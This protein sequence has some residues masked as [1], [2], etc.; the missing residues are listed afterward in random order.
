MSVLQKETITKVD[1]MFKDQVLD[2]FNS[3]MRAFQSSVAENCQ[4]WNCLS[5]ID[6][7]PSQ[8]S[9][10]CAAKQ[11]RSADVC[12]TVT[13]WDSKSPVECPTDRVD[14]VGYCDPNGS[15]YT[16]TGWE[17]AANQVQKILDAFV[18]KDSVD[19]FNV[20]NSYLD[21][22]ATVAM[23]K[24]SL[25]KLLMLQQLFMLGEANSKEALVGYLNDIAKRLEDRYN[26][27]LDM[28]TLTATANKL[29]YGNYEKIAVDCGKPTDSFKN[30]YCFSDF[31]PSPY[32]DGTTISYL[33]TSPQKD[34]PTQESYILSNQI[35]RPSC[36]AS[37]FVTPTNI[38]C[39]IGSFERCGSTT[40]C[41]EA[42]TECVNDK[43]YPNLQAASQC[44]KTLLDLQK[45][46]ID[47]GVEAVYDT[48][49]QTLAPVMDMVQAYKKMSALG[50]M[51]Q[52]YFGYF[53]N[54]GY[55]KASCGP[56]MTLAP[57][58]G[59]IATSQSAS[60]VNETAL[61]P[62][63]SGSSSFAYNKQSVVLIV[64][65]TAFYYLL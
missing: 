27:H 12:K 2:K 37:T 30:V 4:V 28:K 62:A 35:M 16:T 40:Y 18:S 49:K 21:P 34:A 25:V 41:P 61:A 13:A 29:S 55:P 52:E 46:E 39:P 20:F 50:G 1:K 10:T 59:I 48:L 32:G 19:N 42:T 60:L 47:K 8:R 56:A 7:P 58:V 51:N 9:G 43:L 53:K 31:F 38:Y 33:N 63:S 22:A 14:R 24:G 64:L 15:C 57:Q 44:T 36:D 54:K 5:E 11:Q 17:V 3:A 23:T 65:S 6:L 26:A 45:A